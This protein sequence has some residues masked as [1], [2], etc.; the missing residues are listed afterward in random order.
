MYGK[1]TAS[2]TDYVSQAPATNKNLIADE[3]RLDDDLVVQYLEHQHALANEFVGLLS[4]TFIASTK[5][6]GMIFKAFQNNLFHIY[7][8]RLL[9][10]QGLTGSAWP[11]LR[12]A[13]EGLLYAK[14]CSVSRACRVTEV[15]QLR[16]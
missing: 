4:A 16:S 9:T 1:G 3:F 10:Q 11:V 14:F 5:A 8:V 6:K 2:L 13:Y 15:A 12:L 7:S